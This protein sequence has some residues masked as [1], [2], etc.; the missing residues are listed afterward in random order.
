MVCLW[1][2]S[3]LCYSQ[4]GVPVLLPEVL[5][6]NS[7]TSRDKNIFDH[8][9]SIDSIANADLPT[10][11]NPEGSLHLRQRG[12]GQISAISYRGGSSGQT[13]IH[14]N[15]IE[16]SNPMLGQ[17]D[18]SLIHPV[19]F[20]R[21]ALR[22]S[23]TS[24]LAIA[25]SIDINA[26]LVDAPEPK[27]ISLGLGLGSFGRNEQNMNL[28]TTLGPYQVSIRALREEAANDFPYTATS[29]IRTHQEHAFTRQSGGTLTIQRTMGAHHLAYHLWVQDA[30]R[31]IPPTTVQKES[32]STLK[33]LL[34]RHML[35][36]RYSPHSR[37]Q[38]SASLAYFEEKNTFHDPEQSL[39]N[40][41]LSRQ[42]IAQA[43]TE[44]RTNNGHHL[45]AA[46]ETKIIEASTPNYSTENT[47]LRDL[48]G[49]IDYQKNWPRL[50]LGVKISK[51]WTNR[52]DSNP[53]N[54]S[55]GSEYALSKKWTIAAEIALLHRLPGLNDLF[56]IPGGN[57]DLLAERAWNG[58]L[59]LQYTSSSRIRP[60]VAIYYRDVTD[61]IT[62]MPNER[63][64]WAAHNSGHVISRGVEY[65]LDHRGDIGAVHIS[66]QLGYS[67]TRSEHQ[68]TFALPNIS[69]GDQLIYVPKHQTH[70][71]I[72]LSQEKWQ[73]SF[74]HQY[75]SQANGLNGM[76]DDYHTLQLRVG[77]KITLANR[78][79]TASI[80]IRNATN[81]SYFL[82]DNIPMPG[83][84]YRL[85]LLFS[86][87]LSSQ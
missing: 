22:S 32:K 67:Y 60:R 37:W 41:N 74:M 78:L 76:L 9:L 47:D 72:D 7:R 70:L 83:R 31:Q 87:L 13:K 42:W 54:W 24:S 30:F 23:H 48:S 65:S 84:E 55:V 15:G 68:T 82:Y 20:D 64:L 4:Q 66:S 39:E 3:T 44:Y 52:F 40:T 62:W 49:T 21:I 2:S 45:G 8:L 16:I 28:K 33:D 26:R 69:E 18:F 50:N 79:L 19:L 80:E 35:Q 27:Q 17:Q 63:N 6:D 46:I 1:W 10:I 11:L 81:A 56:W 86:N 61:W 73:A 38:H 12:A 51:I 57:P 34:T 85:G 5:V 59:R 75:T 14:W 36:W 29:V 77:R 58:Q 25:G 71:S 53:L 43:G